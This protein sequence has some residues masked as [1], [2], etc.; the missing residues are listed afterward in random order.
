MVVMEQILLFQVLVFQLLHPLVVV[1]EHLMVVEVLQEMVKM[2]VQV[3]VLQERGEQGVLQHLDK[4]IMAVQSQQ[5]QVVDLEVVV[6]A[7]QE[8]H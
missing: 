8:H 6:L 4:V 5:I 2:V 1:V 3:V 7:Q